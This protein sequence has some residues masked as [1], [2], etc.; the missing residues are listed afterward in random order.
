MLPWSNERRQQMI[1]LYLAGRTFVEIAREMKTSSGQISKYLRLAGIESRPAQRRPTSPEREAQI[2]QSYLSGLSVEQCC[3]LHRATSETVSQCLK[4][5]GH[6]MRWGKWSLAKIERMISAYETGLTVRRAAECIG[7]N[8]ATIRKYLNLAGIPLRHE[9]QAAE[10][11]PN[12]KGGRHTGQYIYLR[13]VDHPYANWCGY[14]LEHRLVM[15]EHIGRFLDPEEVVHHR[16]KNKHNNQIDNLEL[17]AS[18]GEH[19]AAE[20]KGQCPKWSA[21]GRQRILEAHRRWCEQKRNQTRSRSD[22]Q[23]SLGDDILT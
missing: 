19:L 16:D 10:K 13:R 5:A 18:N 12:W 15:E 20:L 1:D 2:V 6:E 3:E 11:N 14:V 7:T 22:G 8:T 21:E 9:S 23:A 4:K 17:F